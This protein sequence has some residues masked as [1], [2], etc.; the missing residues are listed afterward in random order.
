[1]GYRG[2]YWP[3]FLAEIS[4]TL[5]FCLSDSACLSQFTLWPDLSLHECIGVSHNRF[6]ELSFQ[7]A[8]GLLSTS[9][10]HGFMAQSER[11]SRDNLLLLM[12][13]GLALFTI[14]L[15]ASL[16]DSGIPEQCTLQKI[17]RAGGVGRLRRA[18]LHLNEQNIGPWSP[19]P[20]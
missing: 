5:F 18:L 8:G 15:L 13:R 3:A 4:S 12:P 1:M 14:A 7:R 11:R 2:L 19:G 20:A 17:D 16:L 9:W 10:F 6:H